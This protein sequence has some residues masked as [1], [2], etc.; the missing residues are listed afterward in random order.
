MGIGK[1]AHPGSG[2]QS[3]LEPGI[4]NTL[5]EILG[6]I[7]LVLSILAAP[8]WIYLLASDNLAAAA[9][10]LLSPG[11]GASLLS[12][13]APRVGLAVLGAMER[14]RR[15]PSGHSKTIDD[16]ETRREL[17]SLFGLLTAIVR[18]RYRQGLVIVYSQILALFTSLML[19]LIS[20][21][22]YLIRY[23]CFSGHS[24]QVMRGVSAFSLTISLALLVW[25]FMRERLAE[26][27]WDPIRAFV[28]REVARKRK[29]GARAHF[30]IQIQQD[31][32]FLMRLGVIAW[33]FT[34][35]ALDV[36]IGQGL[37]GA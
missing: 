18:D 4:A 31:R 1:P 11:V 29:Q 25:L 21:I 9:A 3:T 12:I 27:S 26:T 8:G 10:I 34:Y 30:R 15:V 28:V 20:S 36:I 32:I 33:G 23:L 6:W 17:K 24:A 22:A 35:A 19:I 7:L 13:V 5:L 2:A 37:L 16:E 14:E